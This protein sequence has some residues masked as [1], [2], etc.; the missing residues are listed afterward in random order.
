MGFC[1]CWGSVVAGKE[2]ACE[3]G[4]LFPV[5]NWCFVSVVFSSSKWL[6]VY[7][8]IFYENTW[9]LRIA[10]FGIQ[11]LKKYKALTT[12]SFLKEGNET[13]VLLL[14]MTASELS[15]QTKIVELRL[16]K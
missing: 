13:K 5:I 3:N 15:A 4:Q 6:I 14:T 10:G 9:D 16:R 7:C 8:A 2:G 11:L 12:F 1:F